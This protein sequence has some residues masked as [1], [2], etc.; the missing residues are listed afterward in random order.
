ML[1]DSEFQAAGSFCAIWREGDRRCCF[2]NSRVRSEISPGM[3]S[4]AGF[5]ADP[6]RGIPD[7]RNLRPHAGVEETTSPCP[8]SPI[9][10]KGTSRL[11]LGVLERVS[12]IQVDFLVLVVVLVLVLETRLQFEDDRSRR[13]K[14]A[15]FPGE[16][17]PNLR[18]LTS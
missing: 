2:F 7:R 15:D 17:R 12:R 3:V 5:S 9:C 11:E 18:L 6:P 14:E 4:A 8:F 1:E 10:A 13:R 16:N